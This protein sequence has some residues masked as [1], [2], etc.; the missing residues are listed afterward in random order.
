[1]EDATKNVPPTLTGTRFGIG[2][3]SWGDRLFWGYGQGYEKEDLK[4]VFKASLDAG[5]DFFDTAEVYGQGRSESYLGEFIT[6]DRRPARVATKFMPYPWRLKRANLIKALRAS[7]ERLGMQRVALYQ[8][9]QPLPPISVETWMEGMIEAFQA[10]LIDAVGVSNYDRQRMNRA[11]ERLTREG[12][13]LAS[14]QVEYSLINRRVEKNGLLKACQELGVT[15]IA[16]SPLGLGLLSGK[17]TPDNPP[18]GIRG[19]RYNRKFLAQIQPLIS[20]LRKIGAEHAGKT[21]SQVALNWAMSK[22]TLVIPGAK[23]LDQFEQNKGALGWKLSDQELE[24]LD[25]MSDRV[26]ERH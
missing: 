20:L 11:Y 12:I 13:P 6:E 2:T 23:N 19:A 16:Y 1:M 25:E 8:I 14:N 15:L 18:Q 10:G 26:L 17:Y 22:G 3:W 4:Q 24:A 7:L 9:H 21:P 5:I